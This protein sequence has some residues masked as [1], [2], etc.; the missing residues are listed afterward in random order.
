MGL[1]EAG[2]ALPGWQSPTLP[3]RRDIGDIWWPSYMPERVRAER[4]PL[5]YEDLLRRTQELWLVR[6]HASW[7]VYAR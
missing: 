1:R 2:E 7:D 3:S 6:G 4:L 5:Q